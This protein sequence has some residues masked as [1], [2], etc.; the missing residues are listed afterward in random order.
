VDAFRIKMD[1]DVAHA[2][3]E[4]LN[5]ELREELPTALRRLTAGY[6]MRTYW[7]EIFECLRKISLVGFPVFFRSSSPQQRVYALM[8]CFLT[9]GLYGSYKPYIDYTN[10]LLMEMTQVTIFFSI[11]SSF[12]LDSSRSGWLVTVALPTLLIAPIAAAFLFEAGCLDKLRNFTQ[13]AKDGRL[14]LIGRTQRNLTE[15]LDRLLTVK[16]DKVHRDAIRRPSEGSSIRYDDFARGEDEASNRRSQ[17]RIQGYR[18]IAPH[19]D[20]LVEESSSSPPIA[21]AQQ[22]KA[23]AGM[24]SQQSASV[25]GDEGADEEQTAREP[26]DAPSEPGVQYVELL[27]AVSSSA[28]E[29]SVPAPVAAEES[30]WIDSEVLTQ[31]R[32][33]DEEDDITTPARS[34]SSLWI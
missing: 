16:D 12:L 2:A 14:R 30:L 28:G 22:T 13:P 21:P 27:G 1:A 10:G 32:Q 5:D 26:V 18:G 19:Q 7:F 25:E 23:A 8:I 29:G 3:A 11:S 34:S 20:L 15:C 9:Y 31:L 17:V 24:A 4:A 33:K 6:E